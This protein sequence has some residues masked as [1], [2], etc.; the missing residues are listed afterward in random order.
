MATTNEMSWLCIGIRFL[1]VWVLVFASY[2]PSG[3]S[4]V[5][6]ALNT[7]SGNVIFKIFV[8]FVLVIVWEIYIRATRRSLGDI[9]VC[10]FCCVVLVAD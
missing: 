4:F 2:N 3:Y 9:G 5:D 7:E 10:I 1:I 6:W 8:G